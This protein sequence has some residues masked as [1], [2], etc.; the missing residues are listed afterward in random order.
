M[1][2][3]QTAVV[4]WICKYISGHRIGQDSIKRMTRG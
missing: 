1:T 4:P 2:D 3:R